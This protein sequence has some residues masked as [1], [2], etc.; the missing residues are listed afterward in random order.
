MRVL[1]LL[2]ASLALLASLVGVR[3]WNARASA[4]AGA[5]DASAV[6]RARASEPQ[7]AWDTPDRFRP[8]FDPARDELPAPR[9]G[10]R[11]S[12]HIEDM[13]RSVNYLIENS[14]SANRIND[15]IHERLVQRNWRT[16]EFEPRL[17]KSMVIEDTLVLRDGTELFG[18]LREAGDKYVLTPKSGPTH[19]LRE[20]R[21]VAKGDVTELRK[22]TVYTFTLRDG[23]KWH[24]GQPL[25][26]EDLL[27][28]WRLTK[29]AGVN[30]DEKRFQYDQIVDARA[31]DERTVRFHFAKQ[32]F[33]AT[34]VFEA[35]V[36]LPAH[37]YDLRDP[38]NAKFDADA[39][40]E[41][42]AKWVNEHDANRNWIGLGPYRV[43]EF[44]EQYVEAERFDGYFDQTRAGWVDT[45]RWR[46]FAEDSAALRALIEG[47]LDFTHR[48]LADD[49]FGPAT[50]DQAFSDRFYKGWYYTPRMTY[51]AWNGT[52][53]QFADV[54]VRTAL[55]MCFD[56]DDYIRGFYLGLAQRVTS[57]VFDGSPC[58]DASVQPLPYDI[59][60]A[61]K[62]FAEAG[63][64][65][66]D[67][68]GVL[69]REGVALEFELLQ[70]AGNKPSSV[71]AQ[72]LQESLRSVGV[73]VRIA[74]RDGA[75]LSKLVAER[76]F[77]AVV[78]AWTM[79]VESDPEQ[80]WHSRWAKPGA[81]N[82]LP[83]VDAEV[84]RLIDAMQLELDARVR[85][86][87]G[88]ELHARLYALQP[89][90]YGVKV[91][92][93]FAI[94]KRIRNFRT[95]AIDP[96]YAIRDWWIVDP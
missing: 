37:L 4:A 53:P 14:G 60:G 54:R 9:R 71:L 15:E 29:N 35:F 36:I 63:W 75:S 33:L 10:G 69:D 93:K 62:L 87:L 3:S 13:P 88:R 96:G 92:N 20:A 48:L 39:S 38:T 94:S 65:D 50:N 27:F 24:D 6:G 26:M 17:A 47:E 5:P 43:T 68:D 57:E 51:V 78:R 61:R 45:I 89:Y 67:G 72:K 64:I 46:L 18:E 31:L 34:P 21:E 86:K 42:Q 82:Y 66:R 41:Q 70:Q 56:W 90:M 74:E 44:N 16:L 84:D 55:A 80:V 73:R 58:Y 76:E 19:P 49:Y 52:R 83:V 7:N 22:G 25:R 95:S 30:C 11:V 2:C 81:A 8:G 85:G 77:D 1:S 91:P 28:S 23:V 59:A 40:D 32:F 79:P 12:V